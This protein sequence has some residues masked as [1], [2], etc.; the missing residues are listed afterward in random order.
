MKKINGEV[1]LSAVLLRG[2]VLARIEDVELLDDLIVGTFCR[3]VDL[4][5]D[6]S[7]CGAKPSIKPFCHNLCGH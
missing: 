5:N 6:V 3:A 2:L 4:L 1:H 7:L